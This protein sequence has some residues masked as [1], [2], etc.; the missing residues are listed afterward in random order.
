VLLDRGTY[1]FVTK[2]KNAQNA[3]AIGV[4]I[5][6]N[7]LEI[8]APGIAGTDSSI[9]IPAVMISQPDG[10]TIAGQLSSG[11]NATLG[12]DLTI[13]AGADA[14][15]K[16]L[17]WTPNPVQPGSTISHWDEIATRNHLMEPAIVDGARY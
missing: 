13:R 9:T 14:S 11:V 1:S 16:G 6:D 7:R 5:V 15:G 2:A 4:I 3:A 8:P 10:A 17:L 12:L